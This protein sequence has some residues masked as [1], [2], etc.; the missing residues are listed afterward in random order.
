M[1]IYYFWQGNQ[2]MYLEYQALQDLRILFV[3]A[4][5]VMT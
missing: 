5:P 2:V 4:L 1:S 3:V